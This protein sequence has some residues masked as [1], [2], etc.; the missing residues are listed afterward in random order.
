MSFRFGDEG[1]VGSGRDL[2]AMLDQ[3]SEAVADALGGAAVEAEDEL[4]EIGR[5]MLLGDGAVMGTEQPALGETEHQVDGGQA[6]RR[7]APGGSQVDRLVP[8]AG[9]G[10][11]AVAGPAVGG[12]GRGPGDVLAEEACEAL[13]RDV[14]TTASLS[15]P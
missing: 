7:I 3:P 6:Q 9:G 13:G 2:H 1:A 11:A 12:H 14:G 10:E 8:V 15:P 4:V 5:Q